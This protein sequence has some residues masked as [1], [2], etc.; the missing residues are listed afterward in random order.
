MAEK[1]PSRRR[2]AGQL[3]PKEEKLDVARWYGALQWEWQA[4]LLSKDLD[5]IRLFTLHNDLIRIEKQE[6]KVIEE[7]WP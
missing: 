5:W 2:K 3:P 6:M 7:L 1:K 4:E